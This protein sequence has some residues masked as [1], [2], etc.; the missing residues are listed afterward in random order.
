MV[1]LSR[2]G[3]DMGYFFLAALGLGVFLYFMGTQWIYE[4]ATWCVTASVGECGSLKSGLS[5]LFLSM[6]N[7]DITPAIMGGTPLLIVS[8]IWLCSRK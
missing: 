8:I 6:Y 1:L 2:E 5:T 4:D 7:P 3:G